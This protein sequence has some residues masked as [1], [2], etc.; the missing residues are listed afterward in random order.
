MVFALNSPSVSR[1]VDVSAIKAQV[2]YVEP[3]KRA[4]MKGSRQSTNRWPTD[5]AI[6]EE[7]PME[8][9]MQSYKEEQEMA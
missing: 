2:V 1:P 4:E 6:K 7:E 5:V 9:L 3:I 8:E